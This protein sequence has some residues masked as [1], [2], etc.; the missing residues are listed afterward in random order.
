MLR[1][2]ITIG[3]RSSN[4]ENRNSTSGSVL[5]EPAGTFKCAGRIG[6]EIFLPRLSL[7]N[8]HRT[9]L[10]REYSSRR[11][12]AVGLTTKRTGISVIGARS[13]Q[14]ADSICRIRSLHLE[15]HQTRGIQG[16]R[17]HRFRHY[18]QLVLG[19]S[20]RMERSTRCIDTDVIYIQTFHLAAI[21]NTAYHEVI[22]VRRRTVLALTTQQDKQI[23]RHRNLERIS[24]P[25]AR[26]LRR[27]SGSTR[28]TR[29]F[30]VTGDEA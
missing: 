7:C 15:C 20:V 6:V 30:T 2:V 18:Q 23:A 17:V 5:I 9:A 19:S 25:S 29:S 1:V 8:G 14:T 10:G 12:F 27:N 13:T 26:T 21:R 3:G 22:H 28:S 11:P 24:V 4:S 16:I